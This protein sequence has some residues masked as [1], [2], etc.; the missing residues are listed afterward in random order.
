MTPERWQVI[1]DIVSSTL[2]MPRAEQSAYVARSCASDD[3]LR[4]EVE[5][6]LAASS[7]ADTLPSA[8]AAIAA[9]AEHSILEH[10]LGQ[11]YEIVRSLGRGGMG[12][13]YLARERALERFVAIKVLR[14]DLS[15]IAE[16]RERFRRE[17]RIVAQLSH[18]NILP[19]YTYGETGGLWYFVMAYVRGVTLAERLRVEGRLP[20]EDDAGRD[21]AVLIVEGAARR[22]SAIARR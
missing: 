21:D 15:E 5:S 12:S 3:E 8:R 10:A 9:T 13:V 20:G 19:L 7:G 18:P 4:R 11:Q 1:K 6:L 17:A 22:P 16:G 2:E 14:A